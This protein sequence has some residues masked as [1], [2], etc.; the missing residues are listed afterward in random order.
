MEV[1]TFLKG[2]GENWYE[3]Q[4][5]LVEPDF[6]IQQSDDSIYWRITIGDFPLSGTTSSPDNL[7]QLPDTVV[8]GDEGRRKIRE[9]ILRDLKRVL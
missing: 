9:V 4:L 2:E 5:P 8:G 6:A 7:D 1:K 3:V